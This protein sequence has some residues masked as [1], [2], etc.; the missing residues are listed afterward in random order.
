MWAWSHHDAM[1]L[2]GTHCIGQVREAMT[3][4]V[5]TSLLDDRVGARCTFTLEALRVSFNSVR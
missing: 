2:R 1:K 5:A 4:S 3:G